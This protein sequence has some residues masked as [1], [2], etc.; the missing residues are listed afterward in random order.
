M[1]RKLTLFALLAGLAA[2]LSACDKCGG[3]QELRLPGQPHACRDG[4]PH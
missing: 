4:A 1:M 2:L 3:F